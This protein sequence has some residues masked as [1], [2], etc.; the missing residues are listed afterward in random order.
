MRACKI[1][2]NMV[3]DRSGGKEYESPCVWDK[4]KDKNIL[5]TPQF[6]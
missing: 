4:G 2:K 5:R 3:I 1:N 6:H